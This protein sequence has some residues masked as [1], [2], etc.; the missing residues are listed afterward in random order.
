[1]NNVDLKVAAAISITDRPQRR[2]KTTFF[3]LLN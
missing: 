3:N 2:G 1:V